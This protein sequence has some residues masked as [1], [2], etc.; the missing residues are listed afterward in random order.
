MLV[1]LVEFAEV[2]VRVRS[3]F[4][5]TAV[6]LLW[7]S[8]GSNAGPGSDVQ[9]VKTKK[10]K[11]MIKIKR[12]NF[13]IDPGLADRFLMLAI[14]MFKFQGSGVGYPERKIIKIFS[15][16]YWAGDKFTE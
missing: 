15:N 8:V 10:N 9:A 13:I 1:D 4:E 12:G 6:E 5:L 11:Q 7:I 3:G 14:R 2:G 16:L